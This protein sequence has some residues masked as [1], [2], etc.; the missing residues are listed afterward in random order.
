[1][2]TVA[3][4]RRAAEQAAERAMGVRSTILLVL[5]LLLALAGA[6]RAQDVP[7]IELCTHEA[8]LE[9][10]TGCLQSNVQY[11]QMLIAKNAAAAQQKLTAATA[12]IG[13]L[14]G[15]IASLKGDLAALKGALAALQARLEQLEAA[16]KRVPSPPAA[17]KPKH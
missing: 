2:R 4:G 13:A 6:A 1:V 12:E 11:L 5:A 15:E 14:K 10:R 9:R 7:G 3:R 16:A 17:D 8:T